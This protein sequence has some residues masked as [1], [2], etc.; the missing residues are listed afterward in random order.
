MTYRL[1]PVPP[2]ILAGF[3]Y[4]YY[5]SLIPIQPIK[6]YGIAMGGFYYALL[7]ISMLD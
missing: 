4:A 5:I 6:I 1:S 7:P 3:F 2:R